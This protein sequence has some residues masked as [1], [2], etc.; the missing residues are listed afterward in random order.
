MIN[1]YSFVNSLSCCFKILSNRILNGAK[2]Y[3]R[4]LIEF[5]DL[6]DILFMLAAYSPPFRV[7]KNNTCHYSSCPPA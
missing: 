7:K 3:D 6:P 2:L 1:H 4:I 5:F